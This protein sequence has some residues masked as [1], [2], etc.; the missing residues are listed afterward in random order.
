[1]RLPWGPFSDIRKLFLHGAHFYFV[2]CLSFEERCCGVPLL[3]SRMDSGP[4]KFV[5]VVDPADAFPNYLDEAEQKTLGN[6]TRLENAGVKLEKVRSPLLGSEDEILDTWRTISAGSQEDTLIIDITAF[7]KRYFCLILK[8][9]MLHSTFKNVIV[10]YTMPGTN[11]YTNLHLAED[12]MACDHIPGFAPPLPPRGDT[13]VLSVGFES[14][15]ISS[16]LEVYRDRK[17]G[18]K[19][20]IAFPPNGAAIKRSW[21]TLMSLTRGRAHGIDKSMIAVVATWD[22]EAVYKTLC[23]WDSDSNGLSLAPF[24]PK[25]HSM[26]MALFALKHDCGLYYSQPRSYNP[27]YSRGIGETW[28]YVVKWGGVQCYERVE[29]PM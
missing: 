9:V 20:L 26:A 5:Q 4:L 15:S 22:V 29:N 7:P 10:T 1:M 8:R 3:L 11:G 25:P 12:P 23:H 18:A 27:N 6:Q 14:L 19:V 16:L 13:L 17:R 21:N 2:G 24:G 28:A